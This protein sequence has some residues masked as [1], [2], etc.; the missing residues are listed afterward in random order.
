MGFFNRLV[1]VFFNPRDT[2]EALSKKPVWVDMLIFLL[3]LAA[4]Y[5]ALIAPYIALDRL[6]RL[7]NDITLK[8]EI[9]E[10]AYNQQLEFWRDP[11]QFMITMCIIMQLISLPI[12]FLIQSLIILGLGRLTSVEGKFIQVFYEVCACP[13]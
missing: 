5:A 12:G 2:F 7:E 9:G 6:K 10:E 4:L 1:G 13:G 3:I 8:E 11:P